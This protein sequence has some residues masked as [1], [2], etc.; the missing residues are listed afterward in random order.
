M[1]TIGF[2]Q[3]TPVPCH[4]NERQSHGISYPE[5]SVLQG[6]N[7]DA[8][9][10]VSLA[11]F[12][13][14][15][16]GKRTLT[17]SLRFDPSIKSSAM[18]LLSTTLWDLLRILARIEK[19]GM[20][21]FLPVTPSNDPST[22]LHSLCI[23]INNEHTHILADICNTALT[24]WP[25]YLEIAL[26]QL[27]RYMP[28]ELHFTLPATSYNKYWHAAT[29]LSDF[30]NKG[31]HTYVT[32]QGIYNDHRKTSSKLFRSTL[33][34]Q[35]SLVPDL[36][37]K[38]IHIIELI[39]SATLT[40]Q[41]RV[42]ELAS[43]GFKL[44][45]EPAQQVTKPALKL[46]YSYSMLTSTNFTGSRD[47][48]RGICHGYYHLTTSV[49][50]IYLDSTA[51]ITLNTFLFRLQMSHSTSPLYTTPAKKIGTIYPPSSSYLDIEISICKE[52]LT[53]FMGW[54]SA[55]AEVTSSRER[56]EIMDRYLQK[57]GLNKPEE[58]CFPVASPFNI[59]DISIPKPLPTKPRDNY[60]LLTRAIRLEWSTVPQERQDSYLYAAIPVLLNLPIA[61][62]R[63]GHRL[64]RQPNSLLPLPPQQES[65]L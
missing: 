6:G 29:T 7:K 44:T 45:T 10:Y 5:C 16:L 64:F 18:P 51:I 61:P 36:R 56:L 12:L 32:F 41:G 50:Y 28:L 49:Q 60:R 53:H 11:H 23:L 13:S 38:T 9:Y 26:G 22:H 19:I 3:P 59:L 58:P 63:I 42:A 48:R 31:I 1:G 47:Q 46:L 8:G 30:D 33:D 55:R 17:L 62:V 27:G 34:S 21:Q 24:I 43:S 52:L 35:P 2:S 4:C 20:E 54:L 15:S 25:G 37:S 39:K 40:V 65:T 14:L 57:K